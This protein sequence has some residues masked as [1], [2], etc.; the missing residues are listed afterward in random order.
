MLS[1]LTDH[2]VDYQQKTATITSELETR[3]DVPQT[4]EYQ[5]SDARTR[6][7]PEL[8]HRTETAN[9]LTQAGTSSKQNSDERQNCKIN[10]LRLEQVRPEVGECCSF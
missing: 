10:E 6:L 1:S 8:D 9:Q 2:Q 5:L 4:A 3:L 7:Q